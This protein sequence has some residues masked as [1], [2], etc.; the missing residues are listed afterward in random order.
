M[1]VSTLHVPKVV[2][3]RTG[4]GTECGM[5]DLSVVQAYLQSTPVSKLKAIETETGVSHG[6]LFKI[7]YGYTKAP[8]FDTVRT[9]AAYCRRRIAKE[10]A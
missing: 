7:K 10:A 4:F 6:A 3:N 2:D 9:L 1:N 5:D 8:R